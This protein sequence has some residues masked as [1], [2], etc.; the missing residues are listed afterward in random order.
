MLLSPSACSSYTCKCTPSHVES[1]HHYAAIFR[2]HIEAG[3]PRQLCQTHTRS[4]GPTNS[5]CFS[6]NAEHS[7]LMEFEMPLPLLRDRFRAEFW[8]N[9]L[10]KQPYR[11]SESDRCVADTRIT[12]CR[13]CI[14]II[15]MRLLSHQID[16][17]SQR[18]RT[19]RGTNRWIEN[20]RS[21]VSANEWLLLH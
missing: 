3:K 1:V 19:R 20:E 6:Q 5:I 7:L 11:F 14:C 13:T 15:S 21:H 9:A 17:C 2:N 10:A 4:T 8:K 16:R 12:G 18:S